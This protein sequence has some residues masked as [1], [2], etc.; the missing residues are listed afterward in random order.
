MLDAVTGSAPT[1]TEPGNE[2]LGQIFGSKDVSRTVAGQA[3]QSTGIDAALLKKMLPLLAM[4]VTGY[5]ASQKAGGG[6]SDTGQLLP[7]PCARH[8]DAVDGH[9]AGGRAVHLLYHPGEIGGGIRDT[10]R[11]PLGRRDGRPGAAIGA[12]GVQ[13]GNHRRPLQRR[14]RS[15]RA[16]P[17]W[18]DCSKTRRFAS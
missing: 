14:I 9:R 17:I 1:P 3:A 5:L 12:G 4:A 16:L 6:A 2:I 13:V 18:R 7:A 8:A 11:Q 15:R 10:L